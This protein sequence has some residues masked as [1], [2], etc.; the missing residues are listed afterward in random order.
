MSER[1][2]QQGRPTIDLLVQRQLFRRP[3]LR[4]VFQFDMRRKELVLHPVL[5]FLLRRKSFGMLD[6]SSALLC[7]VLL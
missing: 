3:G 5:Q 6:R 4:L 1:L 2:S 7:T